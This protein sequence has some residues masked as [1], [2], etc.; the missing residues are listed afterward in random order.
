MYLQCTLHGTAGAL[1]VH[2]TS[3]WVCACLYLIAS[4]CQ[5]IYLLIH[6]K[7]PIDIKRGDYIGYPWLRSPHRVNQTYQLPPME[8]CF[9]IFIWLGLWQLIPLF[10]TDR[11]FSSWT[12]CHLMKSCQNFTYVSHLKKSFYC[13]QL[14]HFEKVRTGNFLPGR[15]SHKSCPSS[16]S[17]GGG[18]F[19]DEF[20][21]LMYGSFL[22]I[23]T[24]VQL[25]SI[26]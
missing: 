19:S 2:S 25:L 13:I 22:D 6:E 1:Q 12:I 9:R 5:I 4:F 20:H 24:Y 21:T 7:W 14:N 17:G 16:G 18:S 10:D 26:I 3:V 15:S 8:C 23:N 11:W